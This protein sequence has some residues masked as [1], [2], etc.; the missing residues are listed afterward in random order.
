MKITLRQVEQAG[1]GV[2]RE[3]QLGKSITGK[4]YSATI[5]YEDKTIDVRVLY[6]RSGKATIIGPK[7][8]T[9]QSIAE[10]GKM[11]SWIIPKIPHP[12]Y[13]VILAT[14]IGIITGAIITSL[15]IVTIHK[16][17]DFIAVGIDVILTAL[18]MAI[19]YLEGNKA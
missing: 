13:R 2:I 15:N 16:P 18:L 11:L 17:K 10:F 19:H 14:R 3:E 9:D 12:D 8:I 7:E 1:A 6:K 5:Y 4:I